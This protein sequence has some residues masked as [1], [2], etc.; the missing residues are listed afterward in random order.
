MF[1]CGGLRTE[2]S[3]RPSYELQQFDA[4]VF[5]TL[6]FWGSSSYIA[7]EQ[8][9]SCGG[10]AFACDRILHTYPDEQIPA[11]SKQN[12]DTNLDVLRVVG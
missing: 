4:T 8:N 11:R 1:T 2:P 3:M 5:I 7:V 6:K 10:S 12:V 9:F